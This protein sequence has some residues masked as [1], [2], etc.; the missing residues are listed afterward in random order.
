[1]SAVEL[2]H[3]ALHE[4]DVANLRV[5]VAVDPV[6]LIDTMIEDHDGRLLVVVDVVDCWLQLPQDVCAAYD[7]EPS[8]GGLS[9]FVGDYVDGVNCAWVA[10]CSGT[11]DEVSRMD[12]EE[13]CRQDWREHEADIR[14]RM[15]ANEPSSAAWLQ[16]ITADQ[17]GGPAA[18][19]VTTSTLSAA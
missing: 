14:R 12:A 7:R 18:V 2:Q 13:L 5:R 16:L 4:L 9:R 11:P 8:Y 19:V 3:D 1:M 15:A 10:R 17:L 6:P